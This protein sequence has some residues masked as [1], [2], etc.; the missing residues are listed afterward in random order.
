VGLDTGKVLNHLGSQLRLLGRPAP[1]QS[2]QLSYPGYW[3]F[4]NFIHCLIR[5]Q[6]T[7]RDSSLRTEPYFGTVRGL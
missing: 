6:I 7:L 5:F 1:Y 2:H 4:Y 3:Q